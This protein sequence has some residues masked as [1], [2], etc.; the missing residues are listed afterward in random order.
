[1]RKTNGAKN[2][3]SVPTLAEVAPNSP[4]QRLGEDLVAASLVGKGPAK[5]NATHEGVAFEQVRELLM[6]ETIQSLRNDLNT[7]HRFILQ[8]VDAL[9]TSASSQ[10][11]A[12]EGKV[13]SLSS[14]VSAEVSTRK[15]F[16]DTHRQSMQISAAE[17]KRELAEI[18][19]SAE[20]SM[21]KLSED[22]RQQA[23]FQTQAIEDFEQAM[24]SR[25]DEKAKY[26]GNATVAKEQL[27]TILFD[28]AAAFADPESAT[29]AAQG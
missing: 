14:D 1:M 28:A 2:Q 3:A 9:G 19:Q 29:A 23:S 24:G 26:L 17:L 25:L 20:S 7:S 11:E 15:A 27:A 21:A 16:A 10:L 5:N 22:F 12:I 6:G 13:A 8:R 18:K 4:G